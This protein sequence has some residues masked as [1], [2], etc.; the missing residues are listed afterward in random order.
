MMSYLASLKSETVQSCRVEEATL[1]LRFRSQKLVV[2]NRHRIQ[3]ARGRL[4]AASRLV[5]ARI[6][7]LGRALRQQSFILTVPLSSCGT[8]GFA[9]AP[10]ASQKVERPQPC[11]RSDGTRMI[12]SY[13]Y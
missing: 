10:R 9:G 1:V 11:L 5:G 6:T 4:V 13:W 8:S 2:H 12:S 3:D 7:E